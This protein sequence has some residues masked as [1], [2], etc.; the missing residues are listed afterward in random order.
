MSSS[1][2][3]PA[4]RPEGPDADPDPSSAARSAHGAVRS[5]DREGRCLRIGL[6]GQ[7]DLSNAADLNHVIAGLMDD[8]V[9]QVVFDCAHL[10][11]MDSSGLGVLLETRNRLDS[12]VEHPV[13]VANA[14]ALIARLLAVTGVDVL[15][16]A[17]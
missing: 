4:G 5:A 8:D 11:F 15:L 16:I 9:D 2:E 13:H 6:Q 7:V 10:E 14:P 17:D 3:T 12:R 1:N